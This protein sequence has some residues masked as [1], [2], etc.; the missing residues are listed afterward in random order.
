VMARFQRETVTRN[1]DDMKGKVR[2]TIRLLGQH[3]KSPKGNISRLITLTDARVG[4][5]TE[6]ITKCLFEED[7]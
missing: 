3:G 1:T 2:V 5:V 6:A 4:E 7:E